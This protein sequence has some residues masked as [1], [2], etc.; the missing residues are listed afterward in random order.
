MHTSLPGDPS[1]PAY[2]LDAGR[3]AAVR[4][5]GLLDCGAEEE[6]DRFTRMAA[7][8]VQA[9]IARLSIVDDTGQHF[10][11][12]VGPLP[13]CGRATPLSHAICKHVVGDRAP[14]CIPDTTDD[15]RVASN[16]A[17]T[18]HGTGAYCGQPVHSPDGH[19][20][21]VLCVAD[22]S[23][24]AW[25]QR[26]LE[27]LADLALAI[28]TELSLRA[29][30]DAAQHAE[31]GLAHERALLAEAQALARVGSWEWDPHGG[32][33]RWSAQMYA[34]FGRTPA[35][36]PPS[37]GEF[38]A[39]VHADDRERVADAYAQLVGDQTAFELECRIVGGD[40]RQRTV[41]AHTR[42]DPACPGR[43]IGTVQDVT[44]QRRAD[45]ERLELL[46]ASARA[47]S[48]NRAKSEFLARM[49]H[50]LRTPLNSI[51]GF[52]QVLALE[53]L[54]PRQNED[55]GHILRAGNHLL[56]LVN[57][58]LDLARIESGQMAVSL[59][60]VA[61]A[62]TVRE[63]LALVAPLATERNVRLGIDAS[64][65]GHDRHVYA[66]RN[67]L[68]QVLL[69]LLSN[70]IKY[71]RPGGRVEIS[72]QLTQ[73]AR[74]RTIIADTGIG[75]RPQLLAKLFE[76][77]E[78][79][80]A[81]NTDVTGT[82]LGLALSKRLI[83]AIGGMIEVE[84]TAG[85][86]TTF[87]IELAAAAGPAVANRSTPDDRQPADSGR[88]AARPRLVLYIEDNL[89]NLALVE[90]VLHRQ[91]KIEVISAMQGTIGLELARQ[92]RPDLIVL[93]LHLPDVPGTEVLKR[94]KAD[95]TTRDTPVIVLTADASE[96]QRNRAEAEELGA[97]NYLSKPI[98]VPRFVEIIADNL[99]AQPTRA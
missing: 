45:R 73:A 54:P 40:G 48:A 35:H 17:V 76:P 62:D 3:L 92:H 90:R 50:E 8:L 52:S 56:A 11:S 51:I 96:Q 6:F 63:T 68:K 5:S 99:A 74:V 57:E 36:G 30:L 81:E 79:L 95:P 94:L 12:T 72:F 59:E 33:D 38:V 58:V 75:I 85:V 20:L 29:A 97:T 98:D 9:P 7:N 26:D 34:I 86:G 23:A 41:H 67:R 78:R 80:G 31:A 64:R 28:E 19:V 66:D 82:G 89:S 39:Y 10:K 53:G 13:P 91:A 46:Q 69:N 22:G 93:D 70:A 15:P 60:P 87:V 16:G 65:V 4:Q 37:I 44:R 21:G 27:I 55:V 42:Q 32:E 24:H 49:S 18:E 88:A 43:Y 25:S 83:E 77:F 14:L 71:N 2:V 84:S 1:V 61:L 47:E